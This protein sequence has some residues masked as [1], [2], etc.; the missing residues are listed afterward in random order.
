MSTE[1]YG[2][3]KWKIENRKWKM[4]NRKW[5]IEIGKWKLGGGVR[6]GGVC[7]SGR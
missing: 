1:R 7:W 6:F 4:E 5:K 3:G 2:L